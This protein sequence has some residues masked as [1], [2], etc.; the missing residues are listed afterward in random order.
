MRSILARLVGGGNEAHL[1]RLRPVVA[2]IN[3]LEEHY[4]AL[5]DDQIREEMADVRA[6]VAQHAAPTPP[7]EDELTHPDRERRADM[8]RSREKQDV[9]RLQAALDEVLPDVFAAARE[10][11]RR[12]LAMRPFD[13]Q[14]MGAMVLHQGRICRVEV[15]PVH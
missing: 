7:P 9:K 14:L 1:S 6:E 3:S 5:T 13:V 15:V 2:Q 10:V 4:A 12:K 8:R 11:A